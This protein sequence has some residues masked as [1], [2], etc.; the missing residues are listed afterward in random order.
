MSRIDV[1]KV[2]FWRDVMAR[3]SES[4]LS[5]ARFCREE[6]IAYWKFNH[7]KKRLAVIDD[8][9]ENGGSEGYIQAT[10]RFAEVHLS[11][12][13]SQEPNPLAEITLPSGVSIRLYTFTN[14][15]HL[16]TLL[17]VVTVTC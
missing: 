4:G 8:Q 15:E 2:E 1:T 12:D 11:R 7:W 3:H 5:A 9:G 14:E 10:P 16:A 6:K 17:R 13:H